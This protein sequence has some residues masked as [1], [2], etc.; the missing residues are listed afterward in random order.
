MYAFELALQMDGWMD[1]W[2]DNADS[3]V[4]FVTNKNHS[5]PSEPTSKYNADIYLLTQPW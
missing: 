5:T 4:T 1:G 3:R 2:M